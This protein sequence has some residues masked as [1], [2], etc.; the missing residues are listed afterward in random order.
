MSQC[1]ALRIAQQAVSITITAGVSL[2]AT[3]TFSEQ[4]RFIIN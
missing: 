3:V 2:S 4:K 1:S